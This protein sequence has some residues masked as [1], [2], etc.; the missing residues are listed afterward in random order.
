MFKAMMMLVAALAVSGCAAVPLSADRLER[1][2][3]SMRAAAE[4]GA[5]RVPAAKLHLQMARDQTDT[6]K[7]MAASGNERAP[8]VLARAE[9]DAELAVGMAREAAIHVDALKAAEDL[10]AVQARGDR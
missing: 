5:A 1:D 7:R 10:S 8:L 2:E 9:S 3:A 4:L 6:A